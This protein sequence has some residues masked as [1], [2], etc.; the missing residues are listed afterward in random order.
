MERPTKR[1]RVGA[2]HTNTPTPH[3]ASF[4]P[5]S[6]PS[7]SPGVVAAPH[8][9]K[10]KP[11]KAP[12]HP[13][14]VD[15]GR[16]MTPVVP[17]P[18]FCISSL[19]GSRIPLSPY[20]EIPGPEHSLEDE[21]RGPVDP[22]T[23]EEFRELMRMQQDRVWSREGGFADPFLTNPAPVLDTRSLSVPDGATPTQPRSET[24][25][26]Y[27]PPPRNNKSVYLGEKERRA[28]SDATTVV[29]DGFEGVLDLYLGAVQGS[30][31]SGELEFVVGDGVGLTSVGWGDVSSLEIS[32]RGGPS[33]P[34]SSGEPQES[35]I[36]TVGEYKRVVEGEVAFSSLEP[37]VPK[38]GPPFGIE[39]SYSCCG[40]A[41][42][43]VVNLQKAKA[44]R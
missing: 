37:V 44:R 30:T 3:T 19:R 27:G 11:K 4:P 36:R 14:A 22:A 35:R 42:G 16:P 23:A 24:T 40:Y 9:P 32:I 2:G 26:L 6:P 15:Y 39:W 43:R 17:R 21:L 1:R 20:P 41:T 12:L 13:L 25:A 8:E 7:Q 33:A 29:N 31:L 38:K 10:P 5:P 18:P 34:S 28:D